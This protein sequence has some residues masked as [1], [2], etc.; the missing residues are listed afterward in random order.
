[1]PG[2]GG[3]RPR[4][5]FRPRAETSRL[6]GMSANASPGEPVPR[7]TLAEVAALADVSISTVSKVLNGRIGVSEETRAR[8][9]SLLQTISTTGAA[10]ARITLR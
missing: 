10:R 9:E 1:M 5:R 4:L 6:W 2:R 3:R 7:A 8:V